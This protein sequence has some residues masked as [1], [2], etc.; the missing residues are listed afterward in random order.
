MTLISTLI[1]T[2]FG[3]M[4]VC[5]ELFRSRRIIFDFLFF[6][7]IFFLIIYVVAPL[8]LIIGGSDFAHPYYFYAL[9]NYNMANPMVLLIIIASYIFFLFGYYW[10][11]PA[12]VGRRFKIALRMNNSFLLGIAIILVFISVVAI[13]IYSNEYGGIQSTLS[14]S[15]LIRSGDVSGGAYVF[16]KHFTFFSLIASFIIFSLVLNKGNFPPK[17]ILFPLLIFCLFLSFFVLILNSGRGDVINF[18]IVFYLSAVLYRGRQLSLHYF[19]LIFFIFIMLAL[20]G[21]DFFN[22]LYSG[23]EILIKS[24]NKFNI[25]TSFL[26]YIYKE[27]WSIFSFPYISLVASIA[28]STTYTARCFIDI[29]YG[30]ISFIPERLT[31]I[32]VSNKVEELSFLNTYL[33]TNIRIRMIPCGLIAFFWYSGYLPG[34]LLGSFIYGAIYRFLFELLWRNLNHPLFYILFVHVG[35]TLARF[36]MIGEP[37][38]LFRGEFTWLAF[39]IIILLGSRVYFLRH[40]RS[41]IWQEI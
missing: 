18:L 4:I 40:G 7:N 29:V 34:V 14:Y 37:Y 10:R 5:F 1:L 16:F 20:F 2:I 27:T 3:L 6:W 12:Q 17:V 8:H 36:L 11:C 24:I 41:I 15:S 13:N 33:V 22:A 30:I 19:L 32:P 23:K 31:N 9:D 26:S 35:Y 21:D 28:Q 39:I 38:I 25:E